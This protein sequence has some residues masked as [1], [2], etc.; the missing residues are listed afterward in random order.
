MIIGFLYLTESDANV[1]LEMVKWKE[2]KKKKWQNMQTKQTN[3][4]SCS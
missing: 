4:F 3:N 1:R 2:G